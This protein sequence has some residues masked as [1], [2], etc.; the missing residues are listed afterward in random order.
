MAPPSAKSGV[1]CTWW[2]ITHT[3]LS[4]IYI[5]KMPISTK[6]IFDCCRYAP[7]SNHL[8]IVS[9]RE[10]VQKLLF[11]LNPCSFSRKRI[12]KNFT[13]I[14]DIRLYTKAAWTWVLS[15]LSEPKLN[16]HE[17]PQRAGFDCAVGCVLSGERFNNYALTFSSIGAKGYF[18]V[19]K[20]GLVQMHK[21]FI[22]VDGLILH[23]GIQ[24]NGDDFF[25]F[26]E[27]R[28]KRRYCY[29]KACPDGPGIL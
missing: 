22:K 5:H 13:L 4:S 16:L 8:Q 20:N 19:R 27:K 14:A 24:S 18:Y 26:G 17:V 11:K 29:D 3:A 9:I 21:I 6:F 15:I 10:S 23:I 7:Y 2:G 25:W 1:K 12:L 28:I